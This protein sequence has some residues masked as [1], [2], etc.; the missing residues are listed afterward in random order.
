MLTFG[1]RLRVGHVRRH[2]PEPP[3]EPRAGDEARRDGHDVALV[4]E[5]AAPPVGAEEL[6]ELCVGVG[7]AHVD[8]GAGLHLLLEDG[9]VLDAADGAG[10]DEDDAG[11]GFCE[12]ALEEVGE[13]VPS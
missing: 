11:L 7:V 9:G 1:N 2:E 8:A 3:G 12:L 10:G 13:V 5:L 4:R 6:R